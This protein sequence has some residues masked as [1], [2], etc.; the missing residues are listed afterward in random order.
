M[1]VARYL[2]Y[3]LTSD[4]SASNSLSTVVDELDWGIFG[5]RLELVEMP[6]MH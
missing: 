1:S 3:Y 4:Q 5:P 2:S 6:L